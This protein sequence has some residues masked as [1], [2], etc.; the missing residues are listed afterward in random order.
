MSSFLCLPFYMYARAFFLN[1][2]IYLSFCLFSQ[3]YFPEYLFQEMMIYHAAHFSCR[4]V[5]CFYLYY[6][7]SELLLLIP[8]GKRKKNMMKVHTH[9]THNEVEKLNNIKPNVEEKH[10]I[11]IYVEH[12]K[13][14]LSYAMKNFLH[15][16]VSA[17]FYGVFITF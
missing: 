7:S 14:N 2:H 17:L 9:N 6:R 12:L 3:I 15:H 13:L 16:D 10:S 8:R 4:H 11:N 1:R 5:A